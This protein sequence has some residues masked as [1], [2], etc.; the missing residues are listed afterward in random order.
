LPD[1][2]A[3]PH[4]SHPHQAMGVLCLRAVGRMLQRIP[5][6]GGL[7]LVALWLGFITWLSSHPATGAPGPVFR[8]FL[9][10]SAHAPLFGLLAL[11]MLLCLPR[12]GGWP[13]LD[14]RAAVVV[15]AAVLLA[16]IVDEVHQSFTPGRDPSVADLLTDLVGA[17]CVLWI[18]H[19]LTRTTSTEAGLW[20][21]LALGTLACAACGAIAT[22]C[23][24]LL[25]G[26]P[27]V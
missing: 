9:F 3:A 22:A 12:R 26:V 8:S 18:A 5:R 20:R 21:R 16:G 1:A 2:P 10:N 25:A 23:D 15:L 7:A 13:V 11:W 4:V 27:W 19:F 17:G 24:R 14:R 6:A